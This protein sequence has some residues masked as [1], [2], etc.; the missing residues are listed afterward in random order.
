MINRGNKLYMMN[1]LQIYRLD[2]TKC[3]YS[4]IRKWNLSTIR[5]QKVVEEEIVDNIG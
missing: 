2:Q 3:H 1:Y 4:Y 5:R